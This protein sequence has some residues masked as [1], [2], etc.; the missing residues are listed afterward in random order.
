[1]IFVQA[2]YDAENLLTQRDRVSQDIREAITERARAFDIVLDDVAIT[3]LAYGKEY[4]RA[5]EEKQVA[6]QVRWR[7]RELMKDCV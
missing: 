7:V 5:I 2:R 6:Q 3:H 4:S 1:M